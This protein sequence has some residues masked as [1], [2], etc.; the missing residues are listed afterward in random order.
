MRTKP[1]LLLTLILFPFSVLLAQHWTSS[2][3]FAGY[4]VNAVDILSP[5]YIV[6]GGG[7]QSPDSVQIMFTSTDYGTTWN[8][9]PNDGYASWNKSIAFADT[10]HGLGAGY[11]G[12]IV[13]TSDGGMTW[14]GPVFPINRNFN[15]IVNVSP[16]IYFAVGGIGDSIQTIIMTNNGGTSWSIM[17]DTA[18]PGFN[19][20]FFISPMV[21]FVVGDS[22]MILTTSNGG[23][24]WSAI[25]A[26]IQRNF[27]GI[28]FI[29]ADTGYIVGG[30][31]SGNETRTILQTVNE[32]AT[33]TILE[34]QPGS[35][36]HDIS[37][38]DGVS[39]Y[40]VGDSAAFLQTS[41][42][43]QTWSQGNITGTSGLEYL[44][45]VKF[46][47][48]GFGAVTSFNGFV[49]VFTNFPKPLIQ[50]EQV[51]FK[52][53]DSLVLSAQVNTFQT[54]GNTSFIYSTSANLSNPVTTTS[55][56]T[57]NNNPQTITADISSLLSLP[58]TYYFTCNLSNQDSTYYGDTLA[59]IVPGNLPQLT[60]L[61]GTNVTPNSITLRGQVSS[62]L[63]PADLYFEYQ[64]Q[65]DTSLITVQA[66]PA[67]VYDTLYHAVL[68]N[69][70][71]LLPYTPYHVR[72]KATSGNAVMY[73]SYVQ[74][75]TTPG[76]TVVATLP[77]NGITS[78]TATLQ[79][80][81]G[82]LPF[83]ASIKF[84]YFLFDSS[85]VQ[86]VTATPSTISDTG[87]YFVSAQLTGLVPNSYYAYRVEA[88]DILHT[89]YGAYNYFYNGAAEII[90]ADSATNITYNTATLN[91]H[92]DNIEFPANLYFNYS[93]PYASGGSA[94]P[95]PAT[96]SDTQFHSVL[97]DLSG[98]QPFTQYNYTLSAQE[99]PLQL[100]SNN[101]ATFYTGPGYHNSLVLNTRPAT[102]VTSFNATLN[103]FE[104][105]LPDTAQ[106]F[107]DYWQ[108]GGTISTIPATP[109][110][111]TNSL[112]HQFS[113]PI[114]GLNANTLYLY[115][116]KIAGTFGTIYGDSLSFY[117]GANTIP[118]FDFE[119]WTTTTAEEPDEWINLFGPVQKVSPGAN[120]SSYAVK[121]QSSAEGN[122]VLLSNAAP[123]GGNGGVNPG[124][125]II[126]ITGGFAYA[127]RPDTLSGMFQYDILTGDT[128]YVCI[129]FKSA[130]QVLT[131]QF[132]PVYGSSQGFQRL[133][134]PIHYN[135]AA[136]PVTL[137]LAF[138]SSNIFANFP[139]YGSTMT[140]DNLTFGSAYPP[141]P[142]GD[143]ENWS[144][145]TFQKLDGW[146]Y[147]DMY[148]F[149]YYTNS[150]STCLYQ[151]TGAWHGHY[152]IQ[153]STLQVDGTLLDGTGDISTQPYPNHGTAPDFPLN[154]R[155]VMLTGYYQFFPQNSDTLDIDF[156]L[157]KNGNAIGAGSFVTNQ[158]VSHYTFFSAL[159]NYYSSNYIVPDSASI[160]M[161]TQ[162]GVAMGLS[163]AVIDYLAFDGY[164]PVDTVPVDTVNG[165]NTVSGSVVPYLTIYPNPADDHFTV[166]YNSQSGDP[167][168]LKIYDVFGKVVYQTTISG[169][170]GEVTKDINLSAISP[171]VYLVELRSG[172]SVIANKLVIQ[173]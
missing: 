88:T 84:Q 32:G 139:V 116:I 99:L 31:S 27:D 13:S 44:T 168:Y 129:E 54:P 95:L 45:S 119:N 43:G 5:G 86:T 93:S 113:A 50:D 137:I 29:N 81:I 33:W 94:V 11:Q 149:G 126:S 63:H 165:I 19:S 163:R 76:A 160:E 24:S 58:G 18:G 112:G 82:Y 153:L 96:I 171:G 38:A 66:T 83:S 143:F 155:P 14:G 150:D 55:V 56:I 9:N 49:Y 7:K 162:S 141:I 46:Y 74:F 144:S 105:N 26:P 154:H 117:N 167:D 60:T 12:R 148:N 122:N 131:Q 30:L 64:S 101:S 17:R 157:Y 52:A 106:V 156:F 78:T 147:Q 15:K 146:A 127:G 21:G 91:G 130:G 77:A 79:G 97:V 41:D 3:I 128:A 124:N 92:V 140:V 59:F 71:G 125:G 152:A 136:I 20:A 169:G 34:D 68:A 135:S 98:L 10:L 161:R 120:G 67:F 158:L 47:S 57:D 133:T 159:C 132:M 107:F 110:S 2:N 108:S 138:L 115:R 72:I 151:D 22:G 90:T 172:S 80:Q 173:Q 8:E 42:G 103:G 4:A 75:T 23:S 36:L 170:A 102:Y 70:A 48:P 25:T 114:T 61:H 134:F 40:V 118:N 111:I 39:G 85:N 51:I 53:G 73:S 37:F 62:L 65:L 121:I 16:L 1:I 145:V 69:I 6:T 164:V 89:L 166:Q 100:Q 28:A 35:M 87:F 142:N 104:S 109:D 123:A